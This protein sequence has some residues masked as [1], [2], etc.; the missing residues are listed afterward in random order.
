MPRT[1]GSSAWLSCR[2]APE[3]PMERVERGK[4]VRSVIKWIFE[5]FLPRSTG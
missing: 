3:I 2:F 5:P 4:P 1:S